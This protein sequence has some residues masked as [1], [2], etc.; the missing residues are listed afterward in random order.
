MNLRLFV[1]WIL[2]PVVNYLITYFA[3]ALHLVPAHP[4]ITIPWTTPIIISGFLVGGIPGVLLQI[5]NLVI[6]AI[7]W[8]VF[9]I[10]LDREQVK[11]ESI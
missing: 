3:T 6:A 5:F 4:G 2:V 11:I 1:P 9:F 7:I 8:Y 10:S